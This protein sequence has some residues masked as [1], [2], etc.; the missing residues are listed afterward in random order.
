MKKYF[1]ISYQFIIPDHEQVDF[2]FKIDDKSLNLMHEESFEPSDW[3]ALNNNKCSN[4]PLSSKN[5]ERCPLSVNLDKILSDMS[6]V[7]SYQNIDVKVVTAQ[8]TI[9][10]NTSAQRA[11]SSLMGLIIA[12][13]GCPHTS[14]FKPMARFHLPMAETQET[15]YRA[16]SMYLL[17]QYHR[18]SIGLKPDWE[19]VGLQ[20]IYKNMQ[21]VNSHIAARLREVCE[22]D[23]M[24]NA[25]ILLDLFTQTVPPSIEKSMI[26]M[27][28]LFYPYFVFDDLLQDTDKN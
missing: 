1:E 2:V 22:K 11:L 21:V 28:D 3:T 5:Y 24:L 9:T 10:Q 7:I 13:S 20:K 8:R 19:M 15:I 12:T 18:K 17:S 26:K 4:C 27:Q 23:A 14:F 16:S 25:L 6:R